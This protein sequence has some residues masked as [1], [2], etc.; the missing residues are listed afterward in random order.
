MKTK[1]KFGSLS[2]TKKE[3]SKSEKLI[4]NQKRGSN[5]ESK[6]ENSRVDSIKQYW[7]NTISFLEKKIKATA[8]FKQNH[9]YSK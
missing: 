5:N 2:D 3:P 4:T 8:S 6:K 7:Y 9:S 1:P